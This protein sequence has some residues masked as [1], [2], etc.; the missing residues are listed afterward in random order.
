M[1]VTK[2]SFSLSSHTCTKERSMSDVKYLTPK[3]KAFMGT[4]LSSNFNLGFLGCQNCEKIN[5]PFWN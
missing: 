1:K 5:L 2:I 4:K 3:E